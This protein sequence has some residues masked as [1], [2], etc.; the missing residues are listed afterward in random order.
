MSREKLLNVLIKSIRGRN[1]AKGKEIVDCLRVHFKTPGRKLTKRPQLRGKDD[2]FP[3][4][5]VK[6]R[7]DAQ[8]VARQKQSPLAGIPQGKGE[9]ASQFF[10]GFHSAIF[11]KMQDHFGV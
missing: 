2:A 5:K 3:G 1:V 4:S 10:E 9:H 8:A 11:V 6:K 7:L